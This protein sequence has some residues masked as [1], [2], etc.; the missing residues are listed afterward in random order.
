MHESTVRVRVW[1]F[2]LLFF[3]VKKGVTIL[4]FC[5]IGSFSKQTKTLIPVNRPRA[6]NPGFYN[7]TMDY[8]IR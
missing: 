7:D 2:Q 6:L 5:F 8:H 3:S 4:I 1:T